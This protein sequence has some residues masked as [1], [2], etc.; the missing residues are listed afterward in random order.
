MSCHRQGKYHPALCRT[1]FFQQH[2]AIQQ[3]VTHDYRSFY[4]DEI[5]HRKEIGYPPYSR[6]V[7]IE[8]RGKREQ[9]VRE[10]A[11]AFSTLFPKKGSFYD[12]L[13]PTVPNIPKLRNEYRWHLL[14]K[15]N[16]T[17][18]QGG[19]KIRRLLTGALE[20]Y[21]KRYANTAVTV[22]VDVDAQGVL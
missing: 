12:V 21:Q 13:G 8:F 17:S 15:D 1:E 4:D 18:D 9:G 6:L 14:I 5:I 16:R 3:V 2:P 19:E 20:M 7:L 10:A 22:T 11:F